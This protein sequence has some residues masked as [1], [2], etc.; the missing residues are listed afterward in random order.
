VPRRTRHRGSIRSRARRVCQAA[1]TGERRRAF[2][3]RRSR[4]D[5]TL[6]SRCRA[7]AA[8]RSANERIRA[9]RAGLPPRRRSGAQCECSRTS[10]KSNAGHPHE[11]LCDQHLR[12]GPG[13]LCADADRRDARER[14][15]GERSG[16]CRIARYRIQHSALERDRRQEREQRAEPAAAGRELGRIFATALARAQMTAQPRPQ[17]RSAARFGELATNLRAV[18]FARAPL[19]EQARARLVDVRLDL[20]RRHLEHRADLSVAEAVQLGQHERRA[21]ALRQL[22]N[23]RE[24]LAQAFALLG[25]RRRILAIR[26]DV[27]NLRGLAA[28]A[29]DR[30]CGVSCDR[31]QPWAQIDLALICQQRPVGRSER[32]L[33]GVLRIVSRAED[34]HAKRE[35]LARMTVIESLECPQVAAAHERYEALI[36][37]RTRAHASCDSRKRSRR[38]ATSRHPAPD[39]CPTRAIPIRLTDP[40]AR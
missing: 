5:F 4:R 17:Q 2:D 14:A 10:A 36:R 23:R 19:R 7:V 1:R 16:I 12:S 20:L 15:A 21:L 26:R 24:H 33:Q 39:D 22:A 11:Q 30:Q 27:V 38:Y 25:S 8:R 32:R 34:V 28:L 37:R 13:K 40:L 31:E 6:A 29:Q 9:V 35:Q 3:W 18:D